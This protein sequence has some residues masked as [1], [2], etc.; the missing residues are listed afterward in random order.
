MHQ[1]VKLRVELED[2]KKELSIS[3]GYLNTVGEIFLLENEALGFVRGEDG[4]LIEVYEEL[5]SKS[6]RFDAAEYI[7]IRVVKMIIENKI[8]EIFFPLENF[9]L[10]K[11][12]K[13]NN[14]GDVFY[15][16]VD[17]ESKPSLEKWTILSI[18]EIEKELE[19]LYVCNKNLRK[20]RSL[21][22]V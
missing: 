5:T 8:K 3:H 18:E 7:Y 13:L 19:R 20:S 16:P 10:Y 6:S 17:Y 21:C 11:T 4:I 9:S 15:M 12:I 22:C 14:P 1:I 2:E